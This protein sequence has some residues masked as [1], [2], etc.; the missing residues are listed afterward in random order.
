MSSGY[1]DRDTIAILNDRYNL[2]KKIGKGATSS[3]YLGYDSK[4]KSNELFAFKI[5]KHDNNNNNNTTSFE[6]NKIFQNEASILSNISHPNIVTLYE[7]STNASLK[8]TNGKSKTI[9]FIRTEYL[10]FG[11]LFD[12]VYYPKKGFGEN[13]SRLLMN[14]IISGIEHTHNTGYVHR[15]LKTENIMMN[16]SF[17]VK[18][19]DFGFATKIEGI[20]KNGKHM[21]YLGT[22]V[23]A[24]P[25]LHFKVPYNGIANDIFSLGVIMFVLVTGCLPF[26]MDIPNDQFY[27]CIVKGDYEMFWKKQHFKL[28]ESFMQLFNNMIAFD[29]IQRPS[30]AEI[31]ESEWL[32]EGN[33]SIDNY[34]NL[35]KECIKR[36]SIIQKKKAM[37]NSINKN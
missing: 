25:E 15:D 36:H 28:S 22:P 13:L 35:R 29:P 37:K 5:L 7:S 19:V 27:C 32:R 3:V 2:V 20:N 23:Y 18:I 12:Y 14:S 24:A 11:D 21:Q 10:E 31:K 6:E 26:R 8:K 9:S 4:E 33:Y 16:S 34:Y 1:T 17:N 30:I